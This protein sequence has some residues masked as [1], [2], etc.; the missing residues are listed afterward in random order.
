MN[1]WLI[2]L[3][4]ADLEQC[5][6]AGVFGLARKHILGKVEKGDKI[7][8]CAGKGDWKIIGFGET[9]SDYYV[10]DRAVFLKSG[11]FEFLPEVVF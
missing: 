2:C 11:I 9:T 10:D 5:I 4:R 7:I 1:Y 3:P 8:C 6:K